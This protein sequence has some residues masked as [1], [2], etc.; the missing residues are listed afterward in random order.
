MRYTLMEYTC[1]TSKGI[2]KKTYRLRSYMLTFAKKTSDS[3]DYA[4]A[5]TIQFYASCYYP[6]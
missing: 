1:K 3:S 4:K 2:I 5:N 6:A